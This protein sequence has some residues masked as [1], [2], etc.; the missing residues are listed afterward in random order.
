MTQSVSFSTVRPITCARDIA[1][2]WSQ[3]MAE[4]VPRSLRF[5]D[6]P[7]TSLVLTDLSETTTPPMFSLGI[8]RAGQETECGRFPLAPDGAQ[9]VRRL[10][11]KRH[12]PRVTTVRMRPATVL[13]CPVVLPMA[14]EPDLGRVLGYEI[15]RLTPF[16]A[17]EV[18]WT[19]AV[20]RRDLDNDRLSARLSFVPRS[21]LSGFLGIAEQAGLSSRHCRGAVA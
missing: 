10:V 20:T 21:A 5:W 12:L 19:W 14:T 9:A 2:W 3:Q 8:F 11:A 7:A 15:D 18:F 1:S 4:L 17:D 6:R 16:K 13:D